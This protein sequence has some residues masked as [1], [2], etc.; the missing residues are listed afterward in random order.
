MHSHFYTAHPG[1][2]IGIVILCGFVLLFIWDIF[3][4]EHTILRTYPIVGYLR[5]FAENLGVYL[6]QFFYARDREELPFNRAE[7]NWVYEAAKNIDTTIG[8]GSTRDRRPLGTIYYVDAPFPV[9]GPKNVEPHAVTIGKNCRYPYTTRALVNISAMSYGSISKNATL[10][11]SRG[12]KLAGCWLNTGEGG[13]TTYHLEGGC[14]L[15]AQIGS[16]KYGFRD[17]QGNLS[18]ELL[19]KRPLISKSKCLK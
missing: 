15:V 13:L 2:L 17:K 8:F 12:A 5:Y 1:Y 11:L 14:D 7:R 9:L 4:K 16:A 18:D 3:Q 6:R 10:A 19:K